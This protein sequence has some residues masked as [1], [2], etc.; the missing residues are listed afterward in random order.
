[1][2]KDS[3]LPFL[4]CIYQSTFCHLCPSTTKGERLHPADAPTG[5]AM[6][7]GTRSLR[8]QQFPPSSHDKLPAQTKSLQ[9]RD[10]NHPLVANHSKRAPAPHSLKRFPPQLLSEAWSKPLSYTQIMEVTI[11]TKNPRTHLF[12]LLGKFCVGKETGMERI[13]LPCPALLFYTAH[14]TFMANFHKS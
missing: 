12:F 6:H 9:D 1:M 8:M 3:A 7:P 4:A 2:I 13:L 10:Q 14:P 5:A 11:N